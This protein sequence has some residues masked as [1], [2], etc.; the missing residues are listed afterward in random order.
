[1]LFEEVLWEDGFSAVVAG[2]LFGLC[3]RINTDCD[4]EGFETLEPLTS[5]LVILVVNGVRSL[6]YIVSAELTFRGIGREG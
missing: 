6:T 2:L 3:G 5:M 4:L 1:M